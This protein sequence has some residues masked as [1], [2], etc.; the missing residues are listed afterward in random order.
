MRY[1]NRKLRDLCRGQACAVMLHGICTGG[2]DDTVAAHSNHLAHGKGMG[3]KAH[4]VYTFPACAACHRELDQGFSLSRG[5]KADAIRIALDR[6]HL[7][8]WR[9]G[10]V[11]V[12]A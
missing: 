9:D 4:D 5:A 7:R 11:Q 6:W 10:L 3:I 1:E 12:A 8:M 2:G